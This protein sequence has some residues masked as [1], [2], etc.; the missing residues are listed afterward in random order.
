MTVFT[1]S[2]HFDIV[3]RVWDIFLFEDFKIVLRVCLAL[4]KYFEKEFLG[5][6]FDGIME[7]FK[8]IPVSVDVENLMAIVWEIPLKRHVVQEL[9]D[10]YEMKTY[11]DE[12]K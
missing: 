2:F 7:L 5:L 10:T 1:R 4:I 11:L 8:Q 3:T 9:C 12:K 6:D